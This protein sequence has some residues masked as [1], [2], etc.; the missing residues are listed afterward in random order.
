MSGKSVNRLTMQLRL[1]FFAFH[2]SSHRVPL[3]VGTN[4][5]LA[6]LQIAITVLL[7]YDNYLV[8]RHGAGPGTKSGGMD[9]GIAQIENLSTQDALGRQ[10]LGCC[11][12]SDTTSLVNV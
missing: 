12:C 5:E 11:F 9:E 1:V 2:F 4:N 10:R 8:M 3:G 6:P 7:G